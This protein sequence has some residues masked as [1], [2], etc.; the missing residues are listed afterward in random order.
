VLT[1]RLLQPQILA[2]LAGAGHG[3]KILIAAGNFPA[4]T[5]R[6]PN[7]Q[8][9][10]LAL[11]PGIVSCTDVLSALLTVAVFEHAAVI[12]PPDRE[13]EAGKAEPAAWAEYRELLGAA[14]RQLAL[15]PLE[16]ERFMAEARSPGLALTVATGDE[17]LY[18]SLLLT[19]G[20]VESR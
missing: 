12:R 2:A 15:E 17:R 14:G 16:G 11:A 20:V 10:N 7:T 4:T 18:T 6:G 19:V 1:T 5:Q 8:L 9:V 13:S 3:A